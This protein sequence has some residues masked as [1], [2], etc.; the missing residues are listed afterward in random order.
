MMTM[1][2]CHKLFYT[3]L[4]NTVLLKH[5]E[6]CQ[7]V[8]KQAIQSVKEKKFSLR[9][10]ADRY[11]VPRSTLNKGQQVNLVPKLGRFENTFSE[12][13]LQNVKDL[14]NRL[15]PFLR[16]AFQ[17]AERLKIPLRFNKQK[18]IA[19]KDFY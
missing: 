16:L 11:V 4:S 7:N 14:D 3:P 9:E 1:I 5:P 8:R 13:H 19:D 2:I 18:K 12:D 10:A 6:K 15:M 17:F